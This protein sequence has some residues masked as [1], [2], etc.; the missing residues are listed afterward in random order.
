[1]PKKNL[2]HDGTPRHLQGGNS[3]ETRWFDDIVT[4]EI[5]IQPI[6]EHRDVFPLLLLDCL[7]T[8]YRD[9]ELRYP[10]LKLDA[11]GNRKIG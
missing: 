11:L 10:I 7:C 4:A 3:N 5:R 6:K 1:M 8:Y 9:R 2:F